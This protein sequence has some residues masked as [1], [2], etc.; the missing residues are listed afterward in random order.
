LPSAPRRAGD[1]HP[2]QLDE[3]ETRIDEK[4]DQ[5]DA[6]LAEWRD[7]EVANRLK[8]L[9]ITL[10]FTVSCRRISLGYNWVKN[11]SQCRRDEGIDP[12]GAAEILVR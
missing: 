7:R 5:I 10:I 1:D 6:R 4:L 8:I 9:R 11:L 3:I 2:P 12:V